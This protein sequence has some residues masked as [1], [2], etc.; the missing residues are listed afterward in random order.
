MASIPNRFG[1]NDSKT[2][3]G[4]V[5]STSS[6]LLSY[7]MDRVRKARDARDAD[8]EKRWAEY[9]RLWRGFYKDSDATTNSER[10]KLISPATQQAVEMTAS[11]M[12]EATFG[13]TAWFDVA[14]DFEDEEKDDAVVYRDQLLEDFEL[15]GAMDGV[16][17]TYLLGCVYGTGITKLN[18]G[19]KRQ[20]AFD[21]SQEDKFV[22][23]VEAVRPD[24][25]VIDQSA[26]SIDEAEFVAHEFIKPKHVIKRKQAQG[27]Y[28]SGKVKSWQGVKRA[29]PDGMTS[30]SQ[31]A[32]DNGVL[33]T[34]YF[35]LVPAILIPGTA[36]DNFGLVEAIIT[37]ANE[38][39]ILRAV[40]SPF[41][42][43]DRPFVSYQHD[44]IPGE[45]WGRGV[46]EKGYNPQKALDAE[47]RARIDALGLMSAPMMG[48]DITRMPRNPDLRTK[49]GKFF[50]TRGRPSEIIE[51]ISFNAPALS[52]TFQNAGDLER[53]VQMATGAMDSA[54]P[55]GGNRRNETSS[56]MSQ[57]NSAFLKRSKRTMRRVEKY[58]DTLIRRALWRYMQ[59]DGTRYPQ[60][61]K[62]VVNSTMGL[63]AR[64]VEN[65]QLVQ[66]L[67][68]VPDN[69]PAQ[70]LIIQALFENTN[71]ADKVTLKAAIA[72]MNKPP[73]E[74]EQALQQQ[75][76]QMQV[77]MI[78]QQVRNEKAKADK[79]EAE[80]TL[81]IEKAKHVAIQADLEDDKL[82]IAAA[83]AATGAEKAR[84]TSRQN[85]IAAAKVTV[86]ARKA[87]RETG[88]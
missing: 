13:R 88:K 36:D 79:A 30:D 61:M 20:R 22:V 3:D 70:N 4:E 6:A 8:H 12:E 14:D 16:T 41:T 26:K 53:M 60:D 80:A 25:F 40:E 48:A 21:G 78:K 83:N 43:Q 46:V 35:G 23:N 52:A 69:S 2:P 42:N 65:Q 57:M 27:V 86:E 71:S 77:E 55:V 39:T 38:G 81:A 15:A 17:D 58:L 5:S 68:F 73:S 11:E 59:F 74:E 75:Q 7:V 29:N 50:L 37:V 44:S 51:P 34:E 85:D 56:G 19:L 87:A 18:V 24:E 9:T 31:E 62:F 76:Q 33:I 10:S 63:M 47:L 72:E 32:Q 66:M 64:E 82:E 54:I 28:S 45:F 67:G 49:P 84:Q 1:D